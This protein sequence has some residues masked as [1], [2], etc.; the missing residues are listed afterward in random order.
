[1]NHNFRDLEEV[2]TYFLAPLYTMTAHI[3]FFQRQ[4]GMCWDYVVF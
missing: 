2:E 4:I 3:L 1:M